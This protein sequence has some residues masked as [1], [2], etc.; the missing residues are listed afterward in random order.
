M[1]DDG[2][3][4]CGATRQSASGCLADHPAAQSA[5]GRSRRSLLDVLDIEVDGQVELVGP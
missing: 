1:I 2:D 3:A 4:V 5:C